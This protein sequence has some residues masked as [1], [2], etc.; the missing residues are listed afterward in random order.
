MKI[1][2]DETPL[3]KVDCLFSVYSYKNYK[4]NLTGEDCILANGEC[5]YLQE[6]PTTK[7]VK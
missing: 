5:D 7:E 3:L 6:M 4:C 2:I 1:Y